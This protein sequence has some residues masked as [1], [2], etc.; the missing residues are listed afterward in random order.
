MA[1][2]RRSHRWSQR[3]RV[4]VWEH[5][6]EK[7][8]VGYT[9]N[10]SAAGVFLSMPH[11]L[12]AGTRVRLEVLADEQTFMTEG[13]VVHVRRVPRELQKVKQAG[14]G[15][16]L[17]PFECFL[18][19]VRPSG[20]TMTASGIWRMD[21]AAL[22]AAS[23]A[24]KKVAPEGGEEVPAAKAGGGARTV[25]SPAPSATPRPS[26]SRHRPPAAAPS[27]PTRDSPSR[28]FAREDPHRRV[29]SAKLTLDDQP[30]GETAIDEGLVYAVRF[31]S[32]AEFLRL[33]DTDVRMGIFYVQTRAPAPKGTRVVLDVSPPDA[34]RSV[35]LAAESVRVADSGG[36]ESGGMLVRFLEPSAV[37]EALGVFARALRRG[38]A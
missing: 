38:G 8:T 19:E 36:G 29:S 20:M 15:I 18:Q 4:N 7:P 1:E 30:R 28:Q 27:R 24:G 26:S 17:L 13:I 31:D 3:L 11:P 2:K 10:V 35:R 25:R 32:A 21:S 5:G 12:K 16:E 33:Y 6:G 23:E 14:I 37:V 22:R 9:E 34:G